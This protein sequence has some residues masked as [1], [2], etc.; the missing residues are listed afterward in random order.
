MCKKKCTKCGLEKSEED[1]FWKSKPKN[2]RHSQCKDC[3]REVRKGKEHYKKYKQEYIA[4]AKE[5]KERLVKENRK[6]LLEYFSEHTCVDCPE[7]DPVVLEFDH[8][9]REDK[10]MGIAKMM[11]D[12]TWSQIIEEIE[13][14]EVVC[15]NCHKRRTAKQFSWWKQ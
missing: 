13:K 12:Y 5:R 15:A 4:R 9:I 3:Y 1:F 6:H 10:K 7:N 8:L 14:C 2:K 11:Q